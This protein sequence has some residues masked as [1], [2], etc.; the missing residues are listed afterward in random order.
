METGALHKALSAPWRVLLLS[1]G[2]LTRHLQF[3]TDSKVYVDCFQMHPIG[4]SL[5][6]LPDGTELV[7][8]PRLQR[9]S[10]LRSSNNEVLVYASSWWAEAEVGG[11]LADVQKPI[12][13]NLSE[14]RAE[15]IRDVQRVYLGDSHELEKVF[16]VAGPFWARHYLFYHSGRPITLIYEVFSPCLDSLVGPSIQQLTPKERYTAHAQ[17]SNSE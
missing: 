3:L 13:F 12:W 8:G 4:H 9:Q 11:F 14:K 16:G 17:Y 2:S 10:Y 7:T 5:V 15:L 1:D 6:G